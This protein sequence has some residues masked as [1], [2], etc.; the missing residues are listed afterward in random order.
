MEYSK[1]KT[2]NSQ[3]SKYSKRTDSM[4]YHQVEKIID[5]KM[6]NY[7]LH[8]FVKWKGCSEEAN[9]WEKA[10]NLLNIEEKIKEFEK[11]EKIYNFNEK[12]KEKLEKIRVGSY[13]QGDIPDEIIG[14]FPKNQEILAL[15]KWKRDE[16]GRKIKDSIINTKLLREYDAVL[17]VDFYE[18]KLNV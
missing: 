16:Y 13:E 6:I 8:Y 10:K 9:T 7:K 1:Y 2:R 17:L 15:V 18:K 5:S 14:I 12:Y 11:N 3:K 4:K